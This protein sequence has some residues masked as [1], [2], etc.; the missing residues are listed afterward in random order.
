MSL[1]SYGSDS[2]GFGPTANA[3]VET[4]KVHMMIRE[5]IW[6]V[7]DAIFYEGEIMTALR[8]YILN[9]TVF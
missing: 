1:I 8:R 6:S 4:I 9:P 7:S 5:L 2:N 3:N